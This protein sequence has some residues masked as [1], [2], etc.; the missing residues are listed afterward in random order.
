MAAVR[1]NPVQEPDVL[2]RCAGVKTPTGR[3]P[4]YLPSKWA[5]F[6][7][8]TPTTG[9]PARWACNKHLAGNIGHLGSMVLP[10]DWR[11]Q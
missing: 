5:I 11:R 4:C 1:Q 10:A 7:Q 2:G 8:D 9:A 3:A 6:D